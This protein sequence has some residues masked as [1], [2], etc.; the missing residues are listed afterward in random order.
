MRKLHTG[1]P[2]PR[3]CNL[4]PSDKQQ[5]SSPPPL[6]S[7]RSC[8]LLLLEERS[9]R[10]A[11]PFAEARPAPVLK[12]A[13][14]L[15]GSSHPTVL[16]TSC[17][18]LHPSTPVDTCPDPPCSS[19][20]LSPGYCNPSPRHGRLLVVHALPWLRNGAVTPARSSETN[21]KALHQNVQLL[22]KSH[23]R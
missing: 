11:C 10:G 18:Y 8:S 16:H 15:C 2:P 21:G 4:P 3:L 20:L 5:S 1:K 9:S 17:P 6:P 13:D 19:P 7:L 12:H 22:K 23:S 14:A